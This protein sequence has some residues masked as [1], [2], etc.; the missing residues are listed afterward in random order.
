MRAHL[1]SR[2][3]RKGCRS[4][5]VIASW[6]NAAMTVAVGVTAPG[7]PRMGAQMMRVLLYWAW[8]LDI[9]A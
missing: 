6:L 9:K 1:D 4:R 8:V 3:N 7:A 2:A 5:L